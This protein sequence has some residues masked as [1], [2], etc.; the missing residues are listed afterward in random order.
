MQ[1]DLADTIKVGIQ[2]DYFDLSL[3]LLHSLVPAYPLILRFGGSAP[4]NA[5]ND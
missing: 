3:I 1:R 2:P 5:V 4:L